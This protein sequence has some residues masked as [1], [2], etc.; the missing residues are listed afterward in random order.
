MAA[1]PGT[2]PA[3]P[4]YQP[5]GLM[6]TGQEA[7]EIVSSLTATSAASYCMLI[8]DLVGKAPSVLPT[9]TPNPTDLVMIYQQSTQ[10]PQSCYASSLG[11]FA[12]GTTISTAA[13]SG[14]LNL[15]NCAGTPTATPVNGNGSLVFDTTNSFLWIYNS[16]W[17]HVAVA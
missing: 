17:K 4:Q 13:T 3:L 6:I 7:V 1:T 10:L 12:L 11:I 16:S 9:V 8:T 5:A 2:I 15:P 14:F